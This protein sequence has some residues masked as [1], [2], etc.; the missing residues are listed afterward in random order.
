MKIINDVE[1]CFSPDDKE[2]A[3]LPE[4]LDAT[5]EWVTKLRRKNASWKDARGAIQ[6]YLHH[7]KANPSHVKRQVERAKELVRPWLM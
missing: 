1:P 6:H 5:L 3:F 7:H 4:Q 2:F